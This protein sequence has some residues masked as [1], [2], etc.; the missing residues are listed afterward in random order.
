MK[1]LVTLLIAAGVVSAAA[2]VGDRV[3]YLESRYGDRF[4]T[5]ADEYDATST[6]YGFDKEGISKLS[7]RGF[8]VYAVICSKDVCQEL[9]YQKKYGIALTNNEIQGILISNSMGMEWKRIEGN[10]DGPLFVRTDGAV[11]YIS[12]KNRIEVM[13]AA[14]AQQRNISTT[15]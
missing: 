13:T 2:H 11:A 5:G 12:A 4:S 3:D 1:T 14:R 9:I 6:V 8:E 7:A 15:T 10:V